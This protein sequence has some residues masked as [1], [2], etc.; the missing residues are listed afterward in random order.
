[1]SERLNEYFAAEAAEYLEELELLLA[2][3]GAPDADQFLRLATGVRGSAGMA[4]AE[5]VALVAERLEDAA[6][7]I[8][9]DHIAWSEEIR[10]L[11][12]QT[13]TDLKLL[14]RALHRWGP[15]EERRVREAIE[16]WDEQTDDGASPDPAPAVPIEALFFDDAGPHILS[17]GAGEMVAGT[18]APVDTLLLRGERA[19]QE[20]LALRPAFEAIA[21]G[22]AVP[23]RPLA[24]LVDELFDLLDLTLEADQPGA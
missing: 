17:P 11:S 2:L 5:T 8:V 22:D 16:R 21:R 18:A 7:S 12:E 14:V 24:D 15:D 19:L 23:Q 13:V 9:S 3:P 10:E 1:M 4:G 6:R 20:A